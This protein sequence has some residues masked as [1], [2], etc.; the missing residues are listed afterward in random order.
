MIKV[1]LASGSRK[2]LQLHLLLLQLQ[3]LFLVWLPIGNS[4]K[5]LLALAFAPHANFCQ[6][7]SW[8]ELTIQQQRQQQQRQQQLYDQ[9]KFQ[10]LVS[11]HRPFS[12][13]HTLYGTVQRGDARGAAFL[14]DNVAVSRGSNPIL[15]QIDWRV[16]PMQSWAIVGSNGC[17][18][19]TLL[20]ALVGD[21]A[22]DAG[23]IVVA[24]QLKL[25]YLQQ[26]AVSGS[27]RTIYEEAASAMIEIQAAR[28]ALERAQTMLAQAAENN[29][30]D[31]AAL[32]NL[33]R[34]MQRFEAVG[35]YTQE[36]QVVSVLK[37]LGFA[38]YQIHKKCDQ[39]SGGWQMRV[40]LARLLLSK[41]SLLLLD[42]PSNHLDVNARQWLAQYLKNYD[43]G[44]MILVTHDVN[45]L[46]SVSHIA[47]IT[48]GTLLTY[49]SCTYQQYLNEKERRAAAAQTEFLKNSEKA[50]KLQAFVDRFGASATKA[51]AAQSRVKQLEKM[52]HEGL[53]DAP[54]EAVMQQRFKPNLTL[55]NPPRSMG[56]I[57]LQLKNAHVGH[58]EHHVVVSNVNLSITRGMKL[59]LRGPNGVGKSTIL[60]SLRGTL[61]L[62]QG[63]RIEN[64]LLRLGVF[65]QDLAQELDAQARAVDLVTAHARTDNMHIT[66]QQARSVLGRLGLQGD[67]ALRRIQDLS[68]GEKARV[69]LGMFAMKAS[70]VILLDEPSNH[71]DVEC[72]EALGEGISEWGNK[73]GAIVVISHDRSFCNS[74]PFTHVGTVENGQLKVEQRGVRP[75]D[76]SLFEGSIIIKSDG[77]N[78]NTSNS[79]HRDGENKE[80]NAKLDPEKRKKAFSAP[81]RISKIEQLLEEAEVRIACIDAEMLANGRDIEKLTKLCAKREEE[82]SKIGELMQ[83]WE[84]LEEFLAA[85]PA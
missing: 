33:D 15:T 47:E 55:P 56:D 72:I 61:P 24:Q 6:T 67:K 49:K 84:E 74:I 52:Q 36:Q 77:D 73:D 37:G 45:L 65:T 13:L 29:P 38:D 78:S 81:K 50:A 31:Q 40:A 57:L 9:Q 71:L 58:D 1:P 64:D 83:E 51:S 43:N 30:P 59:L 8:K 79:Y 26:T 42:E 76:W 69:A 60:H 10:A 11:S 54:P 7:K 5:S 75:S 48:S 2:S 66:D 62:I 12:Q 23:T 22:L 27:N 80:N 41:P 85:L 70:N 44:A 18:K 82:E 19:S 25:G 68:G 35:G 14:M 20:K 63:E 39:L 32:V 4:D 34:A 3:L 21:L 16:E 28:E 17:G 46:E 53:L